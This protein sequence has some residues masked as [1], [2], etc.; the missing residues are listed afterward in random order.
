MYHAIVRAKVRS[1]WARIADG[2]YRAAVRLAD[3]DVRFRF[4]GDAPPAASFT[5]R[6]AFDRWFRD[7]LDLFPGIRL[8]P[9]EVIARGWP[10]NTTVVTRFHVEAKL[11]DGTPYRNEGVQW[12]RLRWGR[13]VDDYVL[14]DTARLAEAVRRQSASA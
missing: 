7:L 9:Y 5:G 8:T 11:A 1:L 13:M 10:W 3:P 2:D 12:V 6:D 4:V 14:E